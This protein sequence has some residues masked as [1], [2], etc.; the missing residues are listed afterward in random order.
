[1]H[2]PQGTLLGIIR[3]IALNQ[4]RIEAVILELI[5]TETSRKKAPFVLELSNLN[6]ESPPERRFPKNH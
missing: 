2:A 3:D 6:Q 4:A 1:M 5:Y